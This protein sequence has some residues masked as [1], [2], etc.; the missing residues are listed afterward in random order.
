MANVS[1]IDHTE[2]HELMTT[3]DAQQSRKYAIID[4]RDED[5]AGGNIKGA[6]NEPS[7]QWTEQSAD[8][9][10]KKLEGVENVIFHCALSQVRGPKA[11]RKYAQALER[12]NP[13][14][15]SDER[16]T[17][18]QARSFAPNPFEHQQVA[19]SN[20]QSTKKQNVLVLRN[21]FEGWLEK[22]KDDATLVENLRADRI[23]R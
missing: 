22:Y 11:A 14:P 17:A 8:E 16:P 12:A 3:N 4:V 5:F 1:Y 21:G 20:A 2:L 9:L 23:V 7:E 15:L 6:T 13:S 10:V 19:S 18:E